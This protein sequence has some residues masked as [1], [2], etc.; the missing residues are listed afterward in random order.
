MT[1]QEKLV[2]S[3][4]A[5]DICIFVRHSDS[6]RVFLSTFHEYASLSCAQFST[7]KCHALR[8]GSFTG[9]LRADVNFMN[10]V[11]VLGVLFGPSGV[12][13][14]TWGEVVLR[15]SQMPRTTIS[16]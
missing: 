11:R 9:P 6:F 13:P 10:R 1:G 16:C 2:V 4:Y 14:R 5:D 12:A 7:S 3:A 8:F 15:T